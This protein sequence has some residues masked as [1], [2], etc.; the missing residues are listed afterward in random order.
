VQYKRR[1]ARIW[2]L[3]VALAACKDDSGTARKVS[4][5]PAAPPR[6]APEPPGGPPSCAEVGEHLAAALDMPREVH[7]E[8]KGADV[9]MSG[10]IMRDG[11]VDGITQACRSAAWSH[12]ARV[13]AM[14]WQG[15]IL[16]ERA[17]LRDACPG[18]VK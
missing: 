2:L 9:A 10:D 8:V 13:C 17:L 4:P 11:I 14:A 16:R 7:A 18:T 3:V 1:M 5:A 15:N 6:N 12:D